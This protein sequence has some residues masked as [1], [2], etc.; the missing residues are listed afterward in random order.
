[1]TSDTIIAS[2]TPNE[3]DPSI[4]NLYLQQSSLE[5]QLANLQDT[6]DITEQ[7]F[8]IQIETLSAQTENT[9]NVYDQDNADIQKLEDSIQNFK[10]QQENTINDA[11]KKIRTSGGNAKNLSLYDDLYDQRD[12]IQ[13]ITDDDFSQYL[14]DMANLTEKA[15]KYASGDTFY[16]MFM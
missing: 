7:N 11:F 14:E 6:Y 8:D 9:Q 12:E 5:E 2:I 4:K 10:D 3:D 13:D 15:S 1:V 16:S